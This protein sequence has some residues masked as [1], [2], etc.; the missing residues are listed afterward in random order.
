MDQRNF[1][2]LMTEVLKIINSLSP[3]IM[4]N[5]VIFR[6]NTHNI[7]QE[8][9]GQ[10]TM[11]F[12][13]PAL[14]ANLYEEYKLANSLNIFKRKIKNWKCETYPCRLCQTFQKDLGFI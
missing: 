4:N 14:L 6:K 7:R 2:V 8:R 13:A 10:E 11:K 9:Y 12:R 5:F 3:P 1:Q